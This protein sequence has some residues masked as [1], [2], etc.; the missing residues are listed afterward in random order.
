VR[1]TV[2]L[3]LDLVRQGRELLLVEMWL[4]RAEL[5]EQGRSISSGLSAVAVGLALLPIGLS[6]IFVAISLFIARFGVP[7]DLAF[8]IVALVVI[9][10][11]LLALRSGVRS[12]KPS[13][14]VPA[15]SI[16][17]ISLLLGGEPWA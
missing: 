11:G 15:K 4:A 7:L 3:L 12:L 5:A 1:S 8:L 17:Q 13:R 2:E 10:A 14:L 6:L 16:S 9:V